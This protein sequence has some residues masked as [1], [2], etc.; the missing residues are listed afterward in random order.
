MM[1]PHVEV[2]EPVIEIP[3][4]QDSPEE[5]EERR[6]RPQQRIPQRIQFDQE[7]NELELLL[8]K[9]SLGMVIMLRV[10]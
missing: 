8:K 1:I 4:E 6:A 3:P 5:V 10:L 7:N 9:L 2:E